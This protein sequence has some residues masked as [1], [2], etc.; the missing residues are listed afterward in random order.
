MT[1]FT[2]LNTNTRRAALNMLS[3]LIYNH[4]NPQILVF[5][6]LRAKLMLF[7][8][9]GSLAWFWAHHSSSELWLQLT[10]W[11]YW[12]M[13]ERWLWIIFSDPIKSPDKNFAPHCSN[14]QLPCCIKK[15]MTK[16]SGSSTIFL[17]WPTKTLPDTV[18]ILFSSTGD[19]PIWIS[20]TF[21][22]FAL[23]HSCSP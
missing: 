11:N 6:Q 10:D 15:T 14:Y 3:I 16:C 1:Y 5:T 8:L 7:Y 9:H 4:Q 22:I 18:F 17:V 20:C 19:P 23:G 13:M 12:V 21:W 2:Y